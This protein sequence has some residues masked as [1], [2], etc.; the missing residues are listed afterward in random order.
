MAALRSWLSRSV[1]TLLRYR[2]C[3]PVVVNSKRRC[4]AELEED[5]VWQV[6]IGAR[7]E[8][9]SKQQE[10]LKLETTWMTAVGLSEMAAEAAYQTGADQASVTARNH[11]QLV[12]SQ[13]QEVRQLSPKA[14]TKL[15]EVQTQE[16]HQK[17][18]EVGDE[19]ANQKQEVYLRED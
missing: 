8:M 18:Q 11:N 12:K 10:Y 17:T 1:T 13:V 3:V 2:Q 5:E 19:R 15:A 9:T 14:E 16:L 6:I 4:F 7:V